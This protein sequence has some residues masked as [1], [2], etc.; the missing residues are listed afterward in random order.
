[1]I[2][3]KNSAAILNKYNS[4]MVTELKTKFEDPDINN[5]LDGISALGGEARIGEKML[6]AAGEMVIASLTEV[7]DKGDLERESVKKKYSKNK[8]L[9]GIAALI[10]AITSAGVLGSISASKPNITTITAI[11]NVLSSSFLIYANHLNAPYV[12]EKKDLLEVYQ[13]LNAMISDAQKI[14]M[15]ITWKLRET[16]L[17]ETDLRP[18]IERGEEIAFE[19]RSYIKG[20]L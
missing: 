20:I 19:L 11:L 3:L 17:S 14:K 15:Q 4:S 1:M 18:L 8:R 7:Q 5:M 12:G 10:T 13:S 9:K 6:R 16:P 2:I